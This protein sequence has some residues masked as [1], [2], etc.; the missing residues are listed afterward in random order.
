MTQILVDTAAAFQT[1]S[2][3]GKRIAK[4]PWVGLECIVKINPDAT[5]LGEMVTV[6]L[7]SRSNYD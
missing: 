6:S 5:E 7:G 1:L 2:N 4:A 3:A